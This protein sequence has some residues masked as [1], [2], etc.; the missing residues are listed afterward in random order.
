MINLQWIKCTGDV[1][2][3]LM[4]LNLES[5]GDVSGVYAIWH[6]GQ[7]PTWVRI[8]SGNIKERLSAHR[9][10]PKIIAYSSHG[11]LVTWATVPVSQQL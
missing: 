1:W 5:I 6:G 2:C 7:N 3:G 10:D 11:L 9:N 4:S 8:G